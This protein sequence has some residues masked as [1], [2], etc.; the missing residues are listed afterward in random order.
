MGQDRKNLQSY[1]MVV[2]REGEKLAT[3][4]RIGNGFLGNCNAD[5]NFEN[6]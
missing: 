2:L 5:G 1:V 6:S 4:A 3:W